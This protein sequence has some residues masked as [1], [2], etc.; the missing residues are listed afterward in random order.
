MIMRLGRR[1]LLSHSGQQEEFECTLWS[2]HDT[3]APAQSAP[4][5]RAYVIFNRLGPL[6][7]SSSASLP[8]TLF[9]FLFRGAA[10]PASSLRGVSRPL[11]LWPG[12]SSRMKFTL[13]RLKMRSFSMALPFLRVE[14]PG[15]VAADVEGADEEPLM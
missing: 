14:V 10:P 4:A 7:S 15:L 13:L 6:P 5:P 1:R 8:P 9:F 12:L 3:V 11:S 2:I